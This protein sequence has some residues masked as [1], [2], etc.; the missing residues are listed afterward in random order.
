MRTPRL[1]LLVLLVLGLLLPG[2]AV[3]QTGAGSLTG[4][5]TD[6]SGATVPG[7]TISATNQATNVVYSAVSNDAGN[8]TVLSLPVGTYVVKT[9][10]SGFKSASTRL[11]QVEAM[12]I[13]RL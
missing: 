2:R 11:I 5:V 12:Q 1:L 9:E 3:A 4:L 10:L 8:Y 7:A 13:V 6:Q